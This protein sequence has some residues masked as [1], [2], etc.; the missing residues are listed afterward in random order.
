MPTLRQV[1]MVERAKAVAQINQV[2]KSVVS[3]FNK[4]L[5]GQMT[6][7]RSAVKRKAKAKTNWPSVI[8]KM[9]SRF[10]VAQVA[11][12]ARKNA[13]DVSTQLGRMAKR[14]QIKR[15]GT[16]TFARIR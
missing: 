12:V 4:I 13:R 14:R 1:V 16:G 2:R 7:L 15:T 9:P 5:G 8:S 6:A 10:N 11:R 3:G